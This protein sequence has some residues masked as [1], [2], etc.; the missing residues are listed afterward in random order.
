MKHK[1]LKREKTWL[2]SLLAVTAV[3]AFLA[4]YGFQIFINARTKVK[5]VNVNRRSVENGDELT[6]RNFESRDRTLGDVMHEE[7]QY[8]SSGVQNVN[9]SYIQKMHK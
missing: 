2:F 7:Q 5:Y 1:V 3:L 9:T 6:K 4:G 8:H